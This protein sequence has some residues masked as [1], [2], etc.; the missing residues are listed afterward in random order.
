MFIDI[1]IVVL[2]V[3]GFVR[4]FSKGLIISLFNSIAWVV[5][6][7]IAL[8]LSSS[9]ANFLQLKYNWHS[10]FAPLITFATI[11]ILIYLL[12]HFLGKALEKIIEVAHLGIVNK[13][14]GGILIGAVF[15]F[16][17]S[18]LV[19]LINEGKL[20]SDDTKTQSKLYAFV[21]PISPFVI[22]EAGI[23][24]PIVK[25]TLNDFTNYFNQ[26]NPVEQ[27]AH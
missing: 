9:L 15:L 25:S 19:W 2:V 4:G 18:T 21:E 14:G 20:I 7:F 16:I 11:V 12:V 27:I 5:G 26:H 13:I 8:K 6:I 1:L 10:S 22:D 24:I 23:F 3:F 17:A